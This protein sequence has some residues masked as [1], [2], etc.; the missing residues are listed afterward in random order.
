MAPATIGGVPVRSHGLLRFARHNMH[1]RQLGFAPA[2]CLT[3][4][5]KRALSS[6]R[7]QVFISAETLHTYQ[8]TRFGPNFGHL[9]HFFADDN[10]LNW[11]RSEAGYRERDILRRYEHQPVASGSSHLST[12]SNCQHFASSGENNRDSYYPTELD[13][14]DVE[15]LLP[16]DSREYG[17]R[18]MEEAELRH[19][20]EISPGYYL[21]LRGA[22]ETQW[23]LAHGRAVIV[24]CLLCSAALK[25]ID[26]CQVVICPDCRIVTPNT[27]TLTA[28]RTILEQT[29]RDYT[30]MPQSSTNGSENDSLSK[31]GVGL[32][33]R[34]YR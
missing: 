4:V 8:L 28:R 32:G 12:P 30:A 15:D 27:A 10:S 23:A 21:P 14:L 26:D 2:W 19:D 29:R 22:K 13:I 16:R 7:L 34:V 1:S 6:T 24:D 20:I 9:E 31:F 3:P 11:A 18:G 17:E 5:R 33:V 25:C